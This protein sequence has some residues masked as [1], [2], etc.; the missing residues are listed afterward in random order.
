MHDINFLDILLIEADAFYILD[1]GY[2]DFEHLY[3][4]QQNNA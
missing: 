1:S 4:L 3:S 2:I